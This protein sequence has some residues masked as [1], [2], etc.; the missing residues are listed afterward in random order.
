MR[1][2]LGGCLTVK[3]QWRLL[4]GDEW[5][6]FRVYSQNPAPQRSCDVPEVTVLKDNPLSVDRRMVPSVPPAT[7]VLFPKVTSRRCFDV[8]EVTVL[9]DDPSSVDL[10]M[11]PESPTNTKVLLPN[12]TPLI[13]R[14]VP[15][16]FPQSVTLFPR[17]CVQWFFVRSI[18]LFYFIH[19]SNN[20]LHNF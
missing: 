3:N 19:L 5:G 20:L 9:K 14:D 15:T 8:P 11:V 18:L 10:K 13:S 4:T 7:K 16:V 12:P 2:L 17:V 1:I 6:W